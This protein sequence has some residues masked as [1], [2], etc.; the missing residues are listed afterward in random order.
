MFWVYPLGQWLSD[1]LKDLSFTL[2]KLESWW[3]LELNCLKSELLVNSIENPH[4]FLEVPK[5][6]A[7]FPYFISALPTENVHPKCN[8]N[9]PIQKKKGE[10]GTIN[11]NN[12]NNTEES[13]IE[14]LGM[15]MDILN[16]SALNINPQTKALKRWSAI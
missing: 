15:K 8:M 14:Y 9:Y 13:S 12:K 4:R 11:T 7:T 10:R 16:Y 6:T 5:I 3:C 2:V 1:D